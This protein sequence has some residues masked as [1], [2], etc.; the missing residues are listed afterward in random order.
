MDGSNE[1]E[2]HVNQN[3]TFHLVTFIIAKSLLKNHKPMPRKPTNKISH[4]KHS[5][6]HAINTQSALLRVEW[7]PWDSRMNNRKNNGS[8]VTNQTWEKPGLRR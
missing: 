7:V 1:Q 3:K 4:N 5:T 6:D 8:N 2:P